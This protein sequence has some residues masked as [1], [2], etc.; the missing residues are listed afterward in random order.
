MRRFALASLALPIMLLLA[1][2]PVAADT[3]GGGPGTNFFSFNEV[4]TTS[5]GHQTCIDTNLS[6]SPNGDGTSSACL[7]VFTSSLS[8]RRQTFVSDQFGCAADPVLTV[9][10]AYAVTLA[11]IDISLATCQAH[12]RTCSGAT[13]VT[14]SASDSAVGDV[15]TTTTRST[16]TVGG[17][18]YKTTT[19]ETDV[20]QAGTMT[21]GATTMS[22]DGFLS[23]VKETTTVRC[24]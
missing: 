1:V 18:T 13:I 2:G 3:T 6:V 11:P 10:S 21:I 14:V 19:N 17:C 15:A 16:M 12:K 4:C 9:T 23:I 20:G 7:D 24:K 5:G 8:A 22:E